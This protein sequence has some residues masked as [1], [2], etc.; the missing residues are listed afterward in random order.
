MS[1]DSVNQSELAS[2]YR[3]DGRAAVKEPVKDRRA[4]GGESTLEPSNDSCNDDGVHRTCVCIG[5]GVA[6]SQEA[7]VSEFYLYRESI[8]K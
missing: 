5:V 6:R 2:L 4:D 3:V 8:K 1:D 7:G